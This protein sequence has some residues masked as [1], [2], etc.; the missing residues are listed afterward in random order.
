MNPGDRLRHAARPGR[1]RQDAADA[2]RGT[3]AD[4]RVQ[5]LLG[6]H[7]DARHGAGRRGHRLP[8]RHR[9]R[10]DEAV[11]GRARGQPRRAQQD[12][13]RGRRMGP[14]RDAR[15]DPLADQGE[16]PQLH[17]R[18]HVHQQVPDHRRGAE[19]DAEADE[20]ADHARRARAPR[21]CASA[22]SR[23]STRPTSPRAARASPMSST[24]SRAGRTRG[25]SRCSAASARGSPITRPKRS[26]GAT[27]KM[28]GCPLRRAC[29]SGIAR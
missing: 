16:V 6:D 9:G 11:D 8:A 28:R 29:H 21:S 26:D 12:R 17:A 13:R 20:D 18:P 23:R 3:D 19:P 2:R 25:T 1:H 22:T 5:G 24:A 15:P 27:A 4:A 14:R 7:H 10:E